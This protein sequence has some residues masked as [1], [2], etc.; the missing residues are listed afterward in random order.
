MFQ[1]GILT[2]CC[3]KNCHLR[4]AIIMTSLGCN[5]VQKEHNAPDTGCTTPE[6]HRWFAKNST[7]LR[8]ST[9]NSRSEDNLRDA[10]PKRS[11]AKKTTQATTNKRRL[12]QQAQEQDETWID[13]DWQRF[14]S[15]AMLQPILIDC[16]HCCMCASLKEMVRKWLGNG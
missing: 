13:M 6:T 3:L 12:P 15:I 11:D 5:D 10:T 8:A 9:R 4:E 7:E 14:L 1:N 2:T 16:F